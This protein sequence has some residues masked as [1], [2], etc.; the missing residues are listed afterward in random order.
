LELTGI[1]VPQVKDSYSF[2][3]LL[4]DEAAT[5]GRTHS[6]SEVSNGTNNRRYAIKD[7]RFK[8]LNNLGAWELYDLVADPREATNLYTSKPHA[9]VLASLQAEIAKLKADARPGYFQ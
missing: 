9:A 7:R 5:N 4:S 3:P 1:S 8:L 6:F 2:K